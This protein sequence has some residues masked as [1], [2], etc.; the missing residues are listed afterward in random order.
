MGEIN[1]IMRRRTNYSQYNEEVLEDFIDEEMCMIALKTD[2]LRDLARKVNSNL[3]TSNAELDKMDEQWNNA[4][5]LLET[6]MNR[7]TNNLKRGGNWHMLYLS[8]FV[9]FTFFC[10]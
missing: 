10:I 3:K 7:L 5:D 4:S 6:V 2:K 1:Q 8:L 9:G